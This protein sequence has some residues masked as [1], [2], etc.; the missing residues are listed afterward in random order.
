MIEGVWLLLPGLPGRRERGRPSGA[1]REGRGR[2]STNVKTR[3]SPVRAR[4]DLQPLPLPGLEPRADDLFQGISSRP[5]SQGESDAREPRVVRRII[6]RTANARRDTSPP[7][8]PRVVG[9]ALRGPE[10]QRHTP[11]RLFLELIEG[12]LREV[13]RFQDKWARRRRRGRPGG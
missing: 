9:G 10:V 6:A 3:L 11:A 5:G 7:R 13:P 2:A 1:R 12:Q 4:A 8:S